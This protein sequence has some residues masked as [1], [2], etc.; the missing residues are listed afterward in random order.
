MKYP[1]LKIFLLLFSIGV[2]GLYDECIQIPTR[3]DAEH[4]I[5]R[6]AKIILIH[7]A[8]NSILFY[9]PANIRSRDK[10]ILASMTGRI[11]SHFIA[12]VGA[13]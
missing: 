4:E 6:L 11:V 10:I 3:C 1:K 5:P 13:F 8:R 7:T 2:S 9:W 12:L